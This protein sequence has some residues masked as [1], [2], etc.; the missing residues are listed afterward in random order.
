MSLASLSLLL[1]ALIATPQIYQLAN[2]T[3]WRRWSA[4]FPRSKPIGYVLVLAAT[5]WFLYHV[6]NETLADFSRFKP[7]M[8]AGFGAIGVL[9]CV[10][11]SDFLA[12]RGLA[13]I[14][15]LAAKLMVDTAR[16]HESDWRWVITSLAYA[17][18]I[19][20]IWLTISPW[21]LRDFIAWNNAN[22]G[23][24]KFLAAFRL[25]FAI[26][27]IILGATVLRMR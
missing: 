23:R 16:S 19:A 13:L 20:G 22:D 12:A 17:W 26:L 25:S 7:Y 10:Y 9:T 8:L 5:G 11:V 2:P 24:L 15:L 18:A 1:G 14:L 3:G 27:L 6:Q 4:A 21:R